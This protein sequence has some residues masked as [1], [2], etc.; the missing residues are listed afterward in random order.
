[1]NKLSENLKTLLINSKLS[2]R[3]LS[4]RTSVPQQVINRIIVGK[5]TNPK[6]ETLLPLASYFMV[7]VSQLIG[8]NIFFPDT[9][10]SLNHSGWR[11]IPL[12]ELPNLSSLLL[13]EVGMNSKQM[14]EVDVEV[15]PKG[16]AIKMWDDSME[17]KFPK[18][19]LLVFDVGK[20]IKNGRF[21]IV[22]SHNKQKKYIFRQ[23]M[24]KDKNLLIRCLNP[25]Y[26]C[27]KSRL[28]EPGEEVVAV[29]IQAKIEY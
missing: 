3:E 6:L 21:C 7:S 28:L 15:S 18:G 2:E 8:D 24:L 4:R 11:K 26:S 27:F 14:I 10:I 17:P 16:F 23:I 29:L 22:Y 5:N 13:T 9:K 25:K 12:T 1:M 19:A 20:K